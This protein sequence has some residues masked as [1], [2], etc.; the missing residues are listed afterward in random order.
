MT[1]EMIF[2]NFMAKL[3]NHPLEDG[4]D[5]PFVPNKGNYNTFLIFL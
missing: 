2:S 5:D 1:T 3:R 4:D